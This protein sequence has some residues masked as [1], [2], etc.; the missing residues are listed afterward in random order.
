MFVV[1]TDSFFMSHRLPIALAAIEQGYEVHVATS[2]TTC[3]KQMRSLG[4]IVHPLSLCRRSM[5]IFSN[6]RV[7]FQILR[8]FFLIKPDIV[9]LVTI[10]P[11]LMGGVAARFTSVSSVVVAISGMGF[12]FISQGIKARIRRLIVGQLYRLVFSRQGLT[13][14]FQNKDDQASLIKL[15]QLSKENTRLIRGSGVDLTRYH[16][17]PLPQGQPVVILAA[18]L[19]IDKGVREFVQAARILKNDGSVARFVLVGEPDLG[20]PAT[21][22]DNELRQWVSEGVIEWWGLRNDIP[23]VFTA[24]TLVVLPSYREGLPK[25]LIEAAACGRAV[26]TT[27]VPGCRDAIEPNVTGLLVPVRDSRSLAN[28]IKQLLDNPLLC[29]CMGQAGRKLA[30]RSFDVREVVEQHMHI[31]DELLQGVD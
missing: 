23:Q 15:G 29:E 30:E 1:N 12:I 5:N 27:D 22:S 11:V 13:V 10:K 9:H 28:A 25:V 21:I 7:F 31:Y 14:I 20:N 19:L 18:R 8:L 4:F 16:L 26:I 6:G 24:S 3:E 2:L 17:A